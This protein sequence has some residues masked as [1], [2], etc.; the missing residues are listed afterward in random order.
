M[1]VLVV[2]FDVQPTSTC[3]VTVSACACSWFDVQLT[4]S[5]V[6]VVHV[7]VPVVGCSWFDVHVT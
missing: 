6:L 5:C 7:H 4:S 1:H 3:V 2:G